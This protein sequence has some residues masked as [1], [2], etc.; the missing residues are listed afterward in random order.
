MKYPSNGSMLFTIGWGAANKPAN[1]KPEVL[2]QLSIYAIHHNDSTCARSIG[3]VNVQ[4]CGGLYEGGICYGDSGGPV[5]HWL[6]DRW[7]QVG[8]SS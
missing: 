7:E 3:H 8:I 6:G 1:I 2:Q 4:F 5:F